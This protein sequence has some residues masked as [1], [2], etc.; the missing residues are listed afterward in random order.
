MRISEEMIDEIEVTNELRKGCTM[1]P[2]LFNMYAM[3]STGE[4]VREG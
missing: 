1:A 4:V 2:T 3:C